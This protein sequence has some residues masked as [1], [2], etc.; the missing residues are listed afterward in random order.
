MICALARLSDTPLMRARGHTTGWRIRQ[1]APLNKPASAVRQL[2]PRPAWSTRRTLTPQLAFLRRVHIKLKAHA[3]STSF[4]NCA[5]REATHCITHPG[6]SPAAEDDRLHDTIARDHDVTTGLMTACATG[7]LVQFG[8]WP[9]QHVCQS[10]CLK[11]AAAPSDF[12]LKHLH[13]LDTPVKPGSWQQAQR[14]RT[15][16]MDPGIVS[17]AVLQQS[18]SWTCAHG[19]PSTHCCT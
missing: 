17:T 11:V 18:C 15:V 2:A 14:N 1:S 10:L 9:H 5:D 3:K 12:V 6:N 16:R 13:V 4:G 19:Q 8:C 7:S